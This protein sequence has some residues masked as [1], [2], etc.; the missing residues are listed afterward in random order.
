MKKTHW[1]KIGLLAAVSALP[2]TA[3]AQDYGL[4]GGPPSIESETLGDA[5]DFDAGIA[6]EGA[7][8]S[9]LWQGTSA[10]RAAELLSTA[11]L[12]SEDPIIRDILRTVILSG[13][14][15]PRAINGRGIQSYADARLQAVLAIEGGQSE[16]TSTLDGFLARNPELAQSP[17]AQVDLAF[18][19][20]DW[21]RACEISDTI[22]T[23]RAQPEWARLRATCHALRGETSAADVT[24][25][26]LRSSGY[27]NRAYHAQMDALLTGRGPS[28]EINPS[29]ALVTFLA[30]RGSAAA[31]DSAAPAGKTAQLSCFRRY[32]LD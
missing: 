28:S 14:V 25:D 3:I 22:T 20:G 27:D 12:K 10:L 2:T 6:V 17:M 4:A 18:S 9:N 31:D 11:P 29:D 5:L 32:R 30:T 24:R 7:L 21:K 1:L 19:K 13:G 16:D 26:L 8:D 23:E 15:P